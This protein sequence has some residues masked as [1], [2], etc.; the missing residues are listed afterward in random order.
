MSQ[1]IQEEKL[2]MTTRGK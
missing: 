2:D 1:F